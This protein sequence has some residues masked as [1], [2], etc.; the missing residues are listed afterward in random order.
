M[1]LVLIRHAES[2]HGVRGVIAM[3]SGCGGLTGRGFQ[4]AQALADQLRT[5]GELKDCRALICSP[6]LRAR[7]TADVLADALPVEV[8]EQDGGL[9]E[10]YPGEADGLSWGEYRA[11]FGGFDLVTFPVRPFSPGGES[12]SDFLL[13]VRATLERLAERFTGQTVVAVTHAGFIVASFLVLF[14]IPRPGTGTRLDP[15]HLSLTEWHVSEASWRL[16]RFNDL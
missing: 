6:A 2:E 5:T 15:A 4:Q 10:I 11:K 14:D 16:V 9:C 1:R 12:W 3:P 8:I 7:Q 13:R